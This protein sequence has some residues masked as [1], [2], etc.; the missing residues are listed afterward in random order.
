MAKVTISYELDDIED[1][2]KI[3]SILHAIDYKIA[4]YDI[5]GAIRELLKY[6]EP[7]WLNDEALAFLERL[8]AR[9]CETDALNLQ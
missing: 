9:V 2:D 8:Q 6:S 7:S 1:A 5:H 3:D 4:L